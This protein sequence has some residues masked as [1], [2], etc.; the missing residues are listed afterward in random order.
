MSL[1]TYRLQDSLNIM[2]MT[3]YYEFYT[4]KHIHLY[5]NLSLSLSRIS[6]STMLQ[7]YIRT[8]LTQGIR[9]INWNN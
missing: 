2:S 7:S 1:Q 3:I 4:Q 5:Y 9:K 6:K 8:L